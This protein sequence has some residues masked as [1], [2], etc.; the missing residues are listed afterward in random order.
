LHFHGVIRRLRVSRFTVEVSQH[1]WKGLRD[2]TTI[3]LAVRALSIKAVTAYAT[4][5][6]VASTT[7]GYDAPS[8]AV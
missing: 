4:I 6:E 7:L 5:S 1:S 8:I 2:L 3:G